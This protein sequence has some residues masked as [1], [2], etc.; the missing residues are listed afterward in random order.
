[1]V[2]R[3]SEKLQNKSCRIIQFDSATI[4]GDS[5][6][7]PIKIH[8]V[9]AVEWVDGHRALAHVDEALSDPHHEQ[10]VGV[11]GV[12]LRQLEMKKKIKYTIENDLVIHQ[13]YGFFLDVVNY[14]SSFKALVVMEVVGLRI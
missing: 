9:V 1:M 12:V 10:V 3:N 7:K 8:L 5:L 4:V 11:F 13:G 14:C 6:Q 2:K